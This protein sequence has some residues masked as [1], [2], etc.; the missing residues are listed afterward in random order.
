MSSPSAIASKS[1]S[2]GLS[3]IRISSS[4]RSSAPLYPVGGRE[5]RP[6]SG[7]PRPSPPSTVP[8]PSRFFLRSN[9]LITASGI[10]FLQ[11]AFRHQE[12]IMR[13][14]NFL[15]ILALAALAGCATSDADSAPQASRP[16]I[17]V[18]QSG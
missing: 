1:S 6:P 9:A 14:R 17:Q 10:V 12:N 3:L 2:D 11:P 7:T 13:L 16:D 15:S 8:P 4:S 5:S 18:R